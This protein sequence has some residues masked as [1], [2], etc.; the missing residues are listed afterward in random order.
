MA[1]IEREINCRG[2]VEVVTDYL[3]GALSRADTEIVERHLDS[4]E[5]CRRYLEQMRITIATLGRLRDDDVPLEM[6]E[7]LLGAFRELTQ[8]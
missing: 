8:H 5:G 2:I 4:C 7:R 6:R 1:D 3:E